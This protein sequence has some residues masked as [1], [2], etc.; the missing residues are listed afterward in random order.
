MFS[1][2]FSFFFI[3]L[4][5]L[6]SLF[7]DNYIFILHSLHSLYHHHYHLSYYLPSSYIFTFYS[8]APW[9][10]H[11]KKLAP[12]WEEVAF[13]FLSEKIPVRVARVNCDAN[14]GMLS[15]NVAESS[16]PCANCS[17]LATCSAEGVNGY[18]TIK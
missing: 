16:R 11:C 18:P 10:T 1:S 9:C 8:Y 2:L 13:H 6:S 17:L 15:T 3:H 4:L 5:L 12:V 14:S 7:R